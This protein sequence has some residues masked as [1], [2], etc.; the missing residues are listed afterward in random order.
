ME[1]EIVKLRL[2]HYASMGCIFG[3]SIGFIA[4]SKT[5]NFEQDQIANKLSKFDETQLVDELV[6]LKVKH[7]SI[8]LAQARYE[9][10]HYSSRIYK[11]NRNLFG[12]K[13]AKTR[14]TTA[15]CESRGH[16]KYN[17]WKQSVL[18]YALW[19]TSFTRK[20]SRRDYLKYLKKNYAESAYPVIEEI[21][22]DVKS[23]YP[24]LD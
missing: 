5:P 14:P 16:A 20:L 13:L 12:M 8:V 21:I 17:S 18:D 24:N 9:S 15:L 7:K 10:G 4:F 22:V 1:P 3:F 19:Q 2:I 23:D 6:K 11:L